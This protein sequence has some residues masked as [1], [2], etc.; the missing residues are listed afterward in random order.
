MKAMI[1]YD[2]VFG[3]TAKVA[4]AMAA[5]LQTSARPVNQVTTNQLYGLK[6]LIRPLAKVG[7][8]VGLSSSV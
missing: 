7:Q 2:S 3:N 6:L 5:A 8:Q 4:E 1:I